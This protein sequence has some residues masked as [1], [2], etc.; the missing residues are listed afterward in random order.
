VRRATLAINSFLDQ[1]RSTNPT[2]WDSGR[3]GGL[4]VNVGIRALLMLF[5]ATVKRAESKR[6]NFDSSNAAPEEIVVEA[7][8]VAKP[9]MEYLSSVSDAEFI[10]RFAVRYGSGGP[11]DYFYELSQTIWEQDKHFEPEGLSEYIASK[12][13][14][15]IKD[16]ESTLKF[17]ENRVTEIVINYFKKIHGPHYWN[18]IGTKEM[19]VKAY[20]RQQEEPPEKQLE[21]DVYLDFIDKKKIIEKSE[22]WSVFKPYFDIPLQGEKGYAKNLKWMDRLNELRR[23]VAHPHKR[24]FKPD[25]LAFLEWIKKTFEEELLSIQDKDAALA[26]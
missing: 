21:L 16:A 1:L 9:L 15:R 19:R 8:A 22:N 23:I 10:E 7:V 20:E 18:Y 14:Q 17:I 12:D 26:S 25:D 13:E 5:N 11:M 3:A 2:R 4:C 24:A 6:R